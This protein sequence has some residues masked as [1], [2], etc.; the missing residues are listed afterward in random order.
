[1]ASLTSIGTG[2]IC[3]QAPS[4]SGG[5]GVKV[6]VGKPTS[7]V[8]R[9]VTSTATSA[10]GWGGTVGSVTGKARLTGAACPAE[11]AVSR[12]INKKRKTI[13]R[14]IYSQLVCIVSAIL[15]AC[16]P[17]PEGVRWIALFVNS[18]AG[19]RSYK[20][21]YFQAWLAARSASI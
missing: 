16:K 7:V 18:L 10:V 17:S 14:F 5:F 20:S 4:S 9:S 13:L 3:I 1:M 6:T 19:T 12:L 15:L 21:R 2:G 8:G 11:Q